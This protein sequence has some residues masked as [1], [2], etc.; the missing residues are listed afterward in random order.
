MDQRHIQHYKNLIA[1]NPDK[2]DLIL[3][4]AY[5]LY[6]SGNPVNSPPDL[7][8]ILN[9]GKQYRADQ[10]P[11]IVKGFKKATQEMQASGYGAL[12]LVG[13]AVGSDKLRDY[14]YEGYRRN[15]EEAEQIAPRVNRLE[16][17]GGF[18]DAADWF[19]GT[20]GS[21]GP[22]VIEAGA[23]ALAGGGIGGLAA[24]KAGK[25]AIESAV[26][27]YVAKKMAEGAVE[28]EA[29]QAAMKTVADM[30]RKTAVEAG[31]KTVE[32]GRNLGLVAGVAPVES[33]SMFG[34]AA[35]DVGI[36]NAKPLTAAGL[37]LV[38]AAS[39]V[40]GPEGKLVTQGVAKMTRREALKHVPISMVKEGAQETF[41]QGL[42]DVNAKINNPNTEISGSGYLN[43]FAAGAVGGSAFSAPGVIR[44]WGN[45]PAKGLKSEVD[46]KDPRESQDLLEKAKTRTVDINQWGDPDETSGYQTRFGTTTPA[47]TSAEVFEKDLRESEALRRSDAGAQRLKEQLAKEE[48]ANAP[49]V[50]LKSLFGGLWYGAENTQADDGPVG[51]M[52]VVDPT[53][54]SQIEP[55]PVDQ[56][57]KAVPVDDEYGGMGLPS[58]NAPISEPVVSPIQ[59]MPE[60]VKP[61]TQNKPVG[62][63]KDIAKADITPT[64]QPDENASFVHPDDNY[65]YTIGT[66]GRGVPAVLIK[67]PDTGET[68]DT[69]VFDSSEKAMES[70][71]A[72]KVEA[73]NWGK[74]SPG[75]KEPVVNDPTPAPM[76]EPGGKQSAGPDTPVTKTVIQDGVNLASSGNPYSK[77]GAQKA[78]ATH[79]KTTGAKTEIVDVGE[80]RYGWRV[81]DE[82]KESPVDTLAHEAATSPTNDR[83]EPTEAQKEAGNYKKGHV[84]ISGMD[85][86]IENPEGSSRSGVSEDGKKWETKM[87]SHY[88]YF[89]RTEGKD[90]DQVDVFVRPGTAGVE[91][92]HIV[93]QMGPDGNFDEHKVVLGAKTKIEARREYLRNYEKGWKPGPVSE[94]ALDDFKAWLKDG[95]RSKEPVNKEFFKKSSVDVNETPVRDKQSGFPLK[96]DAQN[97]TPDASESSAPTGVTSNKEPWEMT[98][99]AFLD[100]RAEGRVV[101]DRDRNI[102][103]N[104]V[105]MA[106]NG[107]KPVP[108]YVLKDYPE[109]TQSDAIEKTQSDRRTDSARR[110]TVSEMS[111]D[112]MKRELLT[113]YLTGLGN[114][115]AYEESV[116]K[117]HQV[118]I[119]A[120]ALKWVNDNLGHPAGDALLV[121]I[122]EALKQD[123]LEAYHISGDEYYLQGDDVETLESSIKKAYAY[124]KDNPIEVTLPDGTKA[125]FTGG[126][127]YGRG[128]NIEEAERRLQLHKT[129]RELSG[130]RA[131]RGQEPTRSIQRISEGDKNQDRRQDVHEVNPADEPPATQ[132]KEADHAAIDDP[133]IQV[134]GKDEDD[135][136]RPERK[137]AEDVREPETGRG[138]SGLSE[139]PGRPVDGEV[140]RGDGRNTGRS[141][142]GQAGG[143][144]KVRSKTGND[145]RDDLGEGPARLS[146]K[147]L[148]DH[149]IEPGALTRQGGW[150]TAAKNNLDAIELF[151]K[152]RS[153]NRNATPEE[154]AVLARFAGWGAS[155]LANNLFPGYAERR[156]IIESWAKPEWKD[157]VARLRSVMTDDEIKTAARSTQY[158]HYTSEKVIRSIYGALERMGF[159]GGKI[160]EPG[161]GVGNFIGLLPESMRAATKYTGI[162][163]DHITAGIAKLLYP[164]Q[165][166]IPDDF[167]K[168]DLPHDFFDASIGN[169]PFGSTKIVSDAEYAKYGFSLHNYFF[170]KAID[171]VKPGGLLVFVTSRYTMDSVKDRARNYLADR[172]DLLGAI[173]LPQ[174][175]F[176]EN[177]GTDVVTDVI[178]LRKRGPGESAGGEPWTSTAAI[179]LK[180]KDGVDKEV[181]INEYFEK[182]PEMVLGINAL[183][184]KMYS[185]GEYTV[186][187][188]DGDIEDH[189]AKATKNLPENVYRDRIV[190]ASDRAARDIIERDF[191][192]KNKK[193]GGFYLHDDGKTVMQVKAGAGVA[194][195]S[196][197][198]MTDADRVMV[199]DYVSLRDKLKESHGAQ[200]NDGDWEKALKALQAEYK[201]FVKK[202]GRIREYSLITRTV[203]NDDGQQEKVETR[204]YKKERL[205]KHDAEYSL[206]Y[207][208]ETVT[209]SGEIV[210]SASLKNRT[211]MR[212]KVVTV[213]SVPEAL[214]VSLDKIGRL[215]L[216]HIAEISEKPMDEVVEVL[217]DMI[218]LSPQNETYVLADEYLSGDVVTKL[219]EAEIAAASD[220]KFRKNVEALKK[221]QPEPLTS[222]DISVG[223]GAPWIPFSYYNEFAQDVLGIS[224]GKVKYDR[225][226]GQWTVLSDV[227]A[228]GYRSASDE[229]STDKRGKNEILEA[230]LNNRGIKITE[231]YEV[232]GKKTTVTDK[233]GTAAA[234]EVARKMKNE[235]SAWVWRDVDRAEKLLTIYNRKFNNIAPRKFDGSHLTLPGVTMKFDLYPHQKDAIWRIIQSGNTYLNHA[236]G[237][238][239]TFTMIAA[240]MEMRRIGLINKPLYV[241]PNHMLSQFAQEFQELYPMADVLVADEENFHTNNRKMFVAKATLNNPDAIVMTHSSFQLIKSRRENIEPVKEQFLDQMRYALET[242]VDEK[243][244]KMKIKKMEAMIEQA[245]QR[246]DSLI[247]EGDNVVAFEDMGV[248]FMFV[249]EAHE[250][251]KLDFTTNRQVKGIDSKG[252]RK[253]IDLYIKT[254]W[255]EKMSKGRSHVFASGTPIVN[256][257]G[258]MYSL[259][260]FFDLDGLERDGLEH[261][262]SW[263]NMFGEV[264]SD[265]EMNSAGR[266]EIVERFSKF[267]NIPEMMA[268]VRNFTDV[269]TSTQLGTR[270]ER[271]DIQGGAPEI[272][273]APKSGDLAEYQQRVLQPRIE[274]SKK[275]KPSK[276]QPGNPDPIINIITDGRLASIDLRFVQPGSKNNPNSKLNRYADGII[277]AYSATK[278]NQYFLPKTDKLSSVKGGVQICFFNVGFGSEV[279]KN[280]GFDA[281]SWVMK[282]FK[283]AGIPTAHIAWIDDYETASKKQALFKDLREGKKRILLGSARKMG[284]GVNVQTRL[285]HLHYLDPPWFPADVEQPDGRILRQGN[286]NKNV[287]IKRYATEG[288][289]DAT[290]WQMVARKARFIEQ[291]WTGEKNVRSIEDVS[292]VSQ[293]AMASALASGDQR[294]VQLVGLQAD[295]SRL[296]TLRVAHNENQFKLSRDLRSSNSEALRLTGKLDDYKAARKKFPEY[297]T[298]GSLQGRIDGKV[299]EKSV[300]LNDAI[301]KKIRGMVVDGSDKLKSIKKTEV[302][303][304]NGAKILIETNSWNALNISISLGEN[305]EFFF[306]Q[307]PATLKNLDEAIEINFTT[308][309]LNTINKIPS[310]ISSLER[311]I[312]NKKA[313]IVRI[314]KRIGAKFEYERELNEKFTEMKR[315]EKEL[316]DEGKEKEPES[317]PQNE[318]VAADEQEAEG[319]GEFKMSTKLSPLK[320]PSSISE[321]TPKQRRI[322]R[323]LQ[324]KGKVKA[325]TA[326]EAM[327]ILEGAGVSREKAKYMVAYHGTPHDFDQFSLDKIGTGEGAQ[328]YGHGLY[329]AGN[330][331]VAEWYKNVL[332]Q[333]DI[334]RKFLEKLPEDADF[335]EVMDMVKAGEFSG[336]QAAVL[337][338]L[339][340]NDWLGFDYPAQA[341]SVAFSDNLQ[342]FDPTSELVK[343]VKNYGN[344]YKVDLAP[345]EDEYLLWD[346]PLSEQS[347]TVKKV[348]SEADLDTVPTKTKRMVEKTGEDIY[349]DVA[350]KFHK[351]VDDMVNGGW[352]VVANT[353]NDRFVNQKAAS[354]YLKSIGIRGIKY[355][356]G[357]SRAKGDGHY[358]YVIFDDA[359]VKIIEKYSKDGRIQG[360]ALPDG[361]AFIIP[362][363]IEAGKLWGVVRHEVGVHLGRL[364]Q[365]D[366]GFDRLKRAFE[367]KRNDQTPT[368]EAIRAAYAK[369][370][371]DTQAGH[372]TEEAM[373]YLVESAPE[374]GFVKKILNFIK[375]MMVKLGMSPEIFTADDYVVMAEA[376][377]RR[378]A[379]GNPSSMTGNEVEKPLYS[380]A[381]TKDHITETFS[382]T[383]EYLG[384]LYSRRGDL[385]TG[386]K[387]AW[388][389]RNTSHPG[390]KADVTWFEKAFGLVSHY[391]KKIP[392]FARTFNHA[393]RNQD[394]KT[395][396]EQ[397][398][399]H[400]ENGEKF[401]EIIDRFRRKSKDEYNRLSDYLNERDMNKRGYTVKEKDERFVVRDLGGKDT[402]FSFETEKEALEK[403]ISLEVDDFIRDGGSQ[404]AA[405]ALALIRT[406]NNRSFEL[407]IQRFREVEQM[408]KD[409]GIEIP[410]I[411]YVENGNEIRVDLKQKLIEM[412][413]MRG[414][415]MPR[416]RK[417]G[418]HMLH[419]TKRGQNPVL[420]YYDTRFF[421]N[422]AKANLEKQGYS[423]TVRQAGKLSEDLF[424]QLGSVM[425][426]QAVINESMK[427]INKGSKVVTFEDININKTMDGDTLVLSGEFKDEFIPTLERMG[428]TKKIRTRLVGKTK[429]VTIEY[430]FENPKKGL[431]QTLA[432]E[433]F[434]IDGVTNM[435]QT[436]AL[437]FAGAFVS[438]YA[439]MIRS[440]GSR[441]AMIGR[442]EAVGED[443]T[444][445]YEEDALTRVAKATISLAGGE[446]KAK[447]ALAMVQAITGR[448]VSWADFSEIKRFEGDFEAFEKM[449]LDNDKPYIDR[450]TFDEIRNNWVEAPQ[451][452][453]YIEFINGRGIDPAKQKTAHSEAMA[454][455]KDM[456][457]NEE[458][459]DRVVGTMKGLAV[460]KYLGF[461]VA[462]PVVNMTNMVVGVPAAM[463]GY[464]NI[465]VKSIPAL[466]GKAYRDYR[467]FKTK[468]LEPGELQNVFT[469]I[470]KRGWDQAQFNHEGL[471]AIQNKMQFGYS[472][473]IETSMMLFSWS[474][475]LNRVATITAA[476]NGLLESEPGMTFDERLNRAKE[477]SDKAHGIYGKAN[478]PSM[479]RGGSVGANVMQSFYVFKTFTHNFLATMYDLGVNK[480]DASAV[481]WML[482]SPAIFGAGASMGASLLINAIG[483]AMGSDDPE[484]DFYKAVESRFGSYAGNFSRFGIF[485]TIEN[486][487]SIKGSLNAVGVSDLPTSLGDIMGAP[488]SVLSDVVDGVGQIGRGNVMKGVESILPLA[489]GSP[490]KAYREYTEGITTK[491]N[492]PVFFEGQ[493]LKADAIDAFL[494]AFS[495]NP[496]R[497]AGAREKLWG[498]R[499]A[500]QAFL[501]RRQ[502][503]YARLKKHYNG[504][505]RDY[506]E[507]QDINI[508]IAAYNARAKRDGQK[509]I[510]AKNIKA[511]L[512]KAKVE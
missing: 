423:V 140:R 255:L 447:T 55:M 60:D 209:D 131:V 481:L 178:F 330:R 196:Q 458:R 450:D 504:S 306:N 234:N 260:R 316:E 274:T 116:K 485:G 279:A 414:F 257:L 8:T 294:V 350:E 185:K 300:E 265:Y 413:D 372:V 99:D 457:R 48:E 402:E 27:K 304:I 26:E 496:S 272:V 125:L 141:G 82:A 149:R 258:E 315:L 227:A 351:P 47:K 311:D 214:V 96:D 112:E 19:M 488:G 23:A 336:K 401:I 105:T 478:R 328:V 419:A 303:D 174:T 353:Q 380:M 13:S 470:E 460:L 281:R 430:R 359:D 298:A 475:K 399:T 459:V 11:E 106:V 12:G 236:V 65:Q 444:I 206:V 335:D 35:D 67:K 438:Q 29:R 212:P 239:K 95:K 135:R 219:E 119:D 292:E 202:H 403:A 88:G 20:L 436:V 243:E 387:G 163:M 21:L 454:M 421:A 358:N 428:G 199:A 59:A 201:S 455:F 175:A 62:L 480:K 278:D 40:F 490:I 177:A 355:L 77:R 4:G 148:T 283:D 54:V 392:A 28:T 416:I 132:K 386:I 110:K 322:V 58:V 293:Y 52:P 244:S 479:M 41:Q 431:E 176:K 334:E 442:S 168:R 111:P 453:D 158:A 76:A 124:L 441:S 446:A 42:G 275:W 49:G 153:E 507:L 122:G 361:R 383:M 474:E 1:Q 254:L 264:A 181:R 356:D 231:S 333:K 410:E 452:P 466:I 216:N 483:K 422:A 242:M 500:E 267:T 349:Y 252:S 97:N 102:H 203:T 126:F 180:D 341:I 280:R 39:E 222:K 511:V 205:L 404:D 30:A 57:V 171:R 179:T 396:V 439:D 299:Y 464:G 429:V 56:S 79:S 90:G 146:A 189:F 324:A 186:K 50:P 3:D 9:Y 463:M 240:G 24:R 37:G 476:Y 408:C 512:K 195:E 31:K 277:E 493:P 221:V 91:K 14:G 85:I 477:I 363:N 113:D 217:G 366:T 510:Q 374:M 462:A 45:T 75:K 499:T 288:S 319:G 246:F 325:V 497:I 296:E 101:N 107:G 157:L 197:F 6:S 305:I 388:K 72:L 489:A 128:Q 342:F 501:D 286:Q 384:D 495:F 143:P 38:S 427:E 443:V 225:R 317:G 435:F 276:E 344:L 36:E 503:I 70:F 228:Q 494:R 364:M 150:K 268:R 448:D 289:Y 382:E 249:D 482:F 156:Q 137:R 84:S 78:A 287:F 291:A 127:S 94:M 15:M 332:P 44:S 390:D 327:A 433:L 420:K 282:R 424:E 166:I 357:Q 18:G 161:M 369:V 160:L 337:N 432:N 508:M 74:Q 68:V 373:A 412:G 271:P 66:N 323:Q 248:D 434:R 339:N 165:N 130:E 210:E 259:L 397:Q 449:I 451:Y 491:S 393:L 22:S 92:V 290:M 51:G 270:V 509:L 121:K 71:K 273:I 391:S 467:K 385:V 61:V 471:A 251:R 261:F 262:D 46:K 89:K 183:E 142:Q 93:D 320:N 172:A 208:L 151:K 34:Q 120:D 379:K 64:V 284:T 169:P 377:L 295:V 118:S 98:R 80:G 154:Q 498:E 114:K 220:P 207:A 53:Q 191:N 340:E 378:E 83:P 338:A 347:E 352:G 233:E 370:P 7:D 230:I 100:S 367:A 73:E 492:A 129:E 409:N 213:S 134:P 343:A 200:L 167:I 193:E 43:A 145:V 394:I 302:A 473:M 69:V 269:L 215:D 109:L 144:D 381:D 10:P 108:D 147:S 461:R 138:S 33:G 368:G 321:L 103:K 117:A 301:S 486:G 266:Y 505:D 312:E 285:T 86:A 182:H 170:A 354:E 188:M 190:A 415:Y 263:A 437:R 472:K 445:G 331:Q 250:F 456:M 139:G 123:G 104:S 136:H 87:N 375:R 425:A 223:L 310:E 484:E 224:N 329:F 395:M 468:T 192:P 241:V 232:D 308:R 345:S 318:N 245:E 371:K 297:I 348:L 237:A 376:A 155:E 63:K 247:G 256:T 211:I 326:R 16:D 487:I 400:G 407:R 346:K 218:F 426:Q 204:R 313:E 115:R 229:W 365:N 133:D 469:E 162:E 164:N 465:N 198:K 152:I 194:L 173:R 502:E 81:V 360:F 32:R 5:A 159:P 398:L 184:G 187:E 440:R 226:I 418:E 406:I 362:E 25:E 389:Y 253:S 417:P 235:F 314:K 17:I 309:S 307:T 506:K 238:G 2:K 405:E 411:V